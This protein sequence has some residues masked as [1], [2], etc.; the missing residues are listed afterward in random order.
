MNIVAW[1]ANAHDSRLAS[2]ASVTFRLHF[3]LVSDKSSA[4]HMEAAVFVF[5]TRFSVATAHIHASYL[6]LNWSAFRPRFD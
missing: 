1:H 4:A 3:R 2:V 6:G 5:R